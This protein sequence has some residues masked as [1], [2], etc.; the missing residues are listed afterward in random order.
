MTSNIINEFREKFGSSRSDQA[1]LTFLAMAR[2]TIDEGAK[3]FIDSLPEKVLEAL[4]GSSEEDKA[5]LALVLSLEARAA[6]LNKLFS[7]QN[8][9]HLQVSDKDVYGVDALIN[10]LVK[11]VVFDK[12]M[13]LKEKVGSKE[14][15]AELADRFGSDNETDAVKEFFRMPLGMPLGDTGLGKAHLFRGGSAVGNLY[16]TASPGVIYGASGLG[17]TSLFTHFNDPELAE[18]FAKHGILGFDISCDDDDNHDFDVTLD[19]VARNYEYATSIFG[20]NPDDC[21]WEGLAFTHLAKIARELDCDLDETM[22]V[23]ATEGYWALP[24]E[25][26]AKNS[27][28]LK[29][30][31]LLAPETQEIV[32]DNA[33]ALI[34]RTEEAHLA[35]GVKTRH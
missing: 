11:K 19:D 27:D 31:F 10:N 15:T 14:G 25:H 23:I 20:R 33:L 24:S 4:A 28:A 17:K 8:L 3:E 34:E 18:Q 35:L 1:C 30:F 21:K 32:Y 6:G 22:D 7:S 13:E 16:N 26:K 29:E 2:K 9:D 12:A 5:C